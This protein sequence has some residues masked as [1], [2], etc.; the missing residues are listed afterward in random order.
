[1]PNHL[2]WISM[3]YYEYM[4]SETLKEEVFAIERE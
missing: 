3:D 1:M 4:D 2:K